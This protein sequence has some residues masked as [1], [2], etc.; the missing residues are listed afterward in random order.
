MKI[1]LVNILVNAVCAFDPRG[2]FH[3]SKVMQFRATLKSEFGINLD[4]LSFDQLRKAIRE[5]CV[6]NADFCIY[7]G[8]NYVYTIKKN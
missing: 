8:N 1:S 7:C 6:C 5:N 4:Q 3:P 2:C